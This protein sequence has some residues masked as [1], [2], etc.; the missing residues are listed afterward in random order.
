L[1]LV[2]YKFQQPDKKTSLINA[3]N[4]LNAL[5]PQTS[6]DAETVGIWGAIHKRLWDATQNREDLDE[7]VGAHARGYYIRNDYYNGINY[8]FV[9]D[10]R[11][12]KIEGDEALVDRLLARRVRK[13]VL[14]ICD[15]LLQAA[16]AAVE[17]KHDAAGPMADEL[18]WI[19]ATKV[20][21]LFGLGRRDEAG[22]LKTEIVENERQRLKEIGRDSNAVKWMEDTL[23]KQLGTLGELLPP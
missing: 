20:E 18:F 17:P 14:K 7:S 6:S 9:L 22:S 15:R 23:N 2:T 11:A 5:A 8:A 4:I 12:S 16:S 3:K 10:V 19:R 13:D 1:A 21:A